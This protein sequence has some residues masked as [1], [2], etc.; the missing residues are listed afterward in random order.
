[1]NLEELKNKT[2]VRTGLITVNGLSFQIR[3]LTAA[4]RINLMAYVQ[5][6]KYEDALAY[7]AG[8]CLCG[9]VDGHLFDPNDAKSRA[10]YMSLPSELVEDIQKAITDWLKVN[11][12]VDVENVKNL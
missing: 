8:A 10:E 7:Q 11:S 2:T 6:G 9:D 3:E 12:A 4:E 1:M 5:A